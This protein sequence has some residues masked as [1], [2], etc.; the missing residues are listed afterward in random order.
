MIFFLILCS[1]F[2]Q[3]IVSIQVLNLKIQWTI[4]IVFNNIQIHS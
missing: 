2:V 1:S 4:L 3:K